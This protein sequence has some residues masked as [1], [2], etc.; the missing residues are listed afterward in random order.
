MA[1]TK[2]SGPSGAS[3]PS[4]TPVVSH[5]DNGSLPMLQLRTAYRKEL[6][7][8][9]I[10]APARTALVISRPL[11]GPLG[12][13]ADP[14][15]LRDLGIET[16]YYLSGED[17]AVSSSV[18]QHYLYLVQPTIAQVRMLAQQVLSHKQRSPS[19]TF[20]LIFTPRA[21][22]IAQRELEAAGVRGDIQS[23]SHFAYDLIPL[24]WDVLSLE[25]PTAFHDVTLD[26][27][28]TSLYCVARSV[29]RLQAMFGLIPVVRGKGAQAMKVCNLMQRMRRE[30]DTV[31]AATT[32]LPSTG[33]FSFPAGCEIDELVL[34]DRTVDLMTP[35][36]TQLTY[37]GL[38]DELF[39]IKYSTIEVDASILG[40][41]AKK[42]GASAGTGGG[43][44]GGGG[45]KKL[46][47]TSTDTVF[48]EMRDLSFRSIGSLLQRRLTAVNHTFEQRHEAM[49]VAELKVYMSR[50]KTAHTERQWLTVHVNLADQMASKT[51]KSKLF[52]RRLEIERAM[53]SGEGSVDEAEEYIESA[54]AKQAP[55]Y[56]VLR[57]LSLMSLTSGIRSRKYE[58]YKRDLLHTYGYRCMF[59]LQNL[60]RLG[61][62][63]NQRR[64]YGE[65]RRVMRLWSEAGWKDSIAYVYEGYA[66]LSVR[67]IEMGSVTV[68][69]WKKMDDI[70]QQLPG[71]GFEVRQEEKGK[72][73]AAAAAAAGGGASGSGS[74]VDGLGSMGVE[75]KPLVLVY[76]IGGVTF[77][78]V[79]A[80]RWLSAREGHP[81]EYIVA[82]TKLING[83]SFLESLHPL[84]P[85]TAA[86]GG[87]TSKYA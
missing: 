34:V 2:S 70:M 78:E 56:S 19:V 16:L 81:K 23:I 85:S 44:S 20:S 21:S 54:I 83:N 4:A 87:S 22:H 76:F 41:D 28:P 79:A 36:L 73:A 6:A 84:N 67:L 49:S 68:G 58:Q 55:L 27:D 9:L 30:M 10:L 8:L 39:N 61:L 37:E 1:S 50:F 60:E 86:D 57:L 32:V 62:L 29:M 46:L 15:Y 12:L 5:L 65:I 45:K 74:V 77:A 31:F 64:R 71:T 72:K 40:S 69:G 43:S 48:D 38:I 18:I 13:I 59:L 7:D 24:E 52:D 42:D 11:A 80:L 47:L 17:A 3:S 51:T 66:P 26:G 14:A 33:A 63:S 25:N 82:T 53:L 35:M 75:E